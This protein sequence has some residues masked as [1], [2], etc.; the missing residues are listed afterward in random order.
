MRYSILLL[1]L[2][3]G[4]FPKNPE[5]ETVLTHHPSIK[6]ELPPGWIVD[7]LDPNRPES[8]SWRNVED[9][10]KISIAVETFK[11]QR[12]EMLKK[13]PPENRLDPIFKTNLEGLQEAPRVKDFELKLSGET[14]L[15]GQ[16]ARMVAFT[17]VINQ[18][19][20]ARQV[21]FA[22]DPHHE[23][24]LVT[25]AFLTDPGQMEAFRNTFLEVQNS[26]EWVGEP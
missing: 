11:G 7:E 18:R 8:T 5:I 19:P 22:F 14:E 17:A 15:G 10:A 20:R 16:P 13:F 9:T 3:L 4:C 21:I 12:L 6:V 1:V 23:D 2:L 25:L 26:W 24:R